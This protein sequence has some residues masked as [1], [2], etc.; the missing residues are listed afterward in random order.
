MP[1]HPKRESKRGRIRS[2][3]DLWR[4]LENRRE[5]V[6][7]RSFGLVPATSEGE[8]ILIIEEIGIGSKSD[9][10]KPTS[11]GEL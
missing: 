11:E 5:R 2:F 7:G 9:N 8:P 3:A 10:E 1:Y 6:D 4:A